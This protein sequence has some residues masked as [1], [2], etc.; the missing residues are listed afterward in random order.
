M[1]GGNGRQ[2]V[3]RAADLLGDAVEHPGIHRIAGIRRR[4][5][6]DIA[7]IVH[8][9]R[10]FRIDAAVRARGRGDDIRQR[11]E[12]DGNSMV[13][14]DILQQILRAAGLREVAVQVP[15]IRRIP[16]IPRR[17][18]GEAAAIAHRLGGIRGDR[19]VDNRR[20]GDNVGRLE[21]YFYSMACGNI[22]QQI[23]GAAG[24]REVAIQIPDIRRIPGIRH[25]GESETAADSY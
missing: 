25:R 16:G 11:F 1:V 10:R 23:L 13:F 24:L 18:K 12:R 20:W 22:L 7:A 15:D 17:G 3:L 14:G 21:G 6:G 2:R 19:A 9:E 8:R 4:G 5:E